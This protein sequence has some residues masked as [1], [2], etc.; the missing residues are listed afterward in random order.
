[1]TT[2]FRMSPAFKEQIKAIARAERRTTNNWV[3]VVL[4]NAV[5]AYLE[6]HPELVAEIGEV[7]RD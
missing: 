5:E 6:K 1:M 4:E 3:K 2:S 7:V